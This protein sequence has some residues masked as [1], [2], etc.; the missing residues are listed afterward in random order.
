MTSLD[1][2]TK[3]FDVLK[4]RSSERG[5][6]TYDLEN[7]LMSLFDQQKQR[8]SRFPKFAIAACLG[9]LVTGAAAEAAT[10]VISSMIKSVTLDT[11]NGPQPVR[12]YQTTE[13]P[14]GSK[15]VTVT[16]PEGAKSGTVTVNATGK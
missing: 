15:T 1:P 7:E 16:L 14:D 5:N 8:R 11:G 13:N 9:L 6:S 3:V 12:K 2:M 10:G 4:S